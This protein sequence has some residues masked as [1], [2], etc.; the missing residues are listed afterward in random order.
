MA[1][2]EV[3]GHELRVRFSDWERLA[4]WRA[5]FAVPLAA[6]RTV[7]RVDQ[8]VA[9]ARGGRVGFLVSGVVKVGVWGLG[10]GVRQLVSVR[11]TVPALRIT[12]DRSADGG[13]FNELLISV[14]NA[15]QLAELITNRVAGR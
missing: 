7:E 2:M 4:V 10:T 14:A 15:D 11:R 1:T 8:P 12:L 3:V 13:R 5:E 9:H 6:V